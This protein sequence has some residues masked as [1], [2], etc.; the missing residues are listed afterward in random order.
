M[1]GDASW[2]SDGCGL[3]TAKDLVEGGIKHLDTVP[4]NLV[5]AKQDFEEAAR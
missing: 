4:A 1:G 5:K 3:Q 2:S